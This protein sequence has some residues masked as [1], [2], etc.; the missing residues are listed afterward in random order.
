MTEGL[1]R[2]HSGKESACQCRRCTQ[3][4][5]LEWE[6]PLEDE[7]ATHSNILAWKIP[8]T[9]EPGGLQSVGSLRVRRDWVR[10]HARTQHGL[11]N[12]QAWS[13]IYFN[14]RCFRKYLEPTH[15]TP[16]LLPDKSH[17]QRSLVGYSPWDHKESDT[18]EQ[19]NPAHISVIKRFGF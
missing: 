13:P 6:E 16:V 3:V 5:S 1:P 8:W 18:T 4:Q 15:P 11:G 7:V 12:L 19:L 14:T 9:E 17:G 2:R 10:T